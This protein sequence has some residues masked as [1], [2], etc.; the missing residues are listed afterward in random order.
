MEK[1]NQFFLR[2]KG[3]TKMICAINKSLIFA[4]PTKSETKIK[5]KRVMPSFLTT[6][7]LS[8]TFIFAGF[9]V[10]FAQPP[11]DLC[12]DAIPLTVG[13]VTSGTTE[14][15]TRDEPPEIDCGT[16]VTAP[17]VWYTVTGT[18]NTMTAST[19]TDGD[20]LTGSADYDTKISVYCADCE[21]PICVTGVDDTGGC[22]GN[23]TSVSWPS[24]SGAQYL[25]L[26]HG[27]S[28]YTGNFDLAILDD[29]LP[30]VPHVECP[31]SPTADNFLG[32]LVSTKHTKHWDKH[33]K[34]WDKHTKHWDRHTKHWGRHTKHWGP[35]FK[36]KH[37]FLN[38]QFEKGIFLAIK[39]MQLLNPASRE[40][41]DITDPDTHLVSYWI[42]RGLNEPKHERVFG[43]H[44][45]NQFGDLFVD[46]IMPDR[47][48]IPTAKDLDNP[49][50]PPDPLSHNVDQFK[51]YEVEITE[52]TPEFEPRLGVSLADKFE[53]KLYDVMRPTRLCVPVNM[54]CEEIKNSEIP[55]MCYKIRRSS[56]EA[57][58]R[59]VHGIYTNNQ[60]GPLKLSTIKDME[61]CVPSKMIENAVLP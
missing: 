39:P 17:G 41:N 10:C 52:G 25:I 51:C 32:Y 9:A 16:A 28:S 54:N 15:A 53:D 38:D 36:L 57:W 2:R 43:I 4:E 56:G 1:K 12:E 26:V 44:V 11:N 47:L 21:N 30:A 23:S 6:T 18:G 20:P 55:L 35:K 14:D 22:I 60:L 33:T 48:L 37:V 49:V 13:S 19:C 5:G 3:G 8:L 59:R 24:Q 58:H 46:T 40:G 29:E 7:L 34:H 42:T 45:T 50:D 27:F 61:L 31:V